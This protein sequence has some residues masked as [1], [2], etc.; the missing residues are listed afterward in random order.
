MALEFNAKATRFIAC[1]IRVKDIHPYK[2][3][4]YP[5]KIKAES[6]CG[7]VW[8]VDRNG[9]KLDNKKSVKIPSHNRP[10]THDQGEEKGKP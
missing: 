3:A 5:N 7:P 1:P 4:R 9:K 6:V 8:E 10:R 2:N